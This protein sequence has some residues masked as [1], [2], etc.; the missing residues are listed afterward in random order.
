MFSD[1]PKKF[2]SGKLKL[3]PLRLSFK[4]SI[5][6]CFVAVLLASRSFAQTSTNNPGEKANELS[7]KAPNQE[8]LSTSIEIQAKAYVEKMNQRLIRAT[9]IQTEF[10]QGIESLRQACGRLESGK[11][12]TQESLFIS[13][14]GSE[15]TKKR[16]QIKVLLAKGERL[17]QLIDAQTNRYCLA[18]LRP[19]KRAEL[20][21]Q[22]GTKLSRF[23]RLVDTSLTAQDTLLA[24]REISLKQLQTIS[25]CLSSN[26]LLAL[27]T[28]LNRDIGKL[29]ADIERE[30]AS[31]L[32]TIDGLTQSLK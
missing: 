7:G 4:L 23:E 14:A 20:I 10:D 6:I 18:M 32:E 26:R 5:A 30:I 13:T 22:T 9:H 12:S 3:C 24:Q 16:S 1:R 21:C 2:V 31:G 8:Q 15:I 17:K 19:T 11:T 27:N 28:L 25:T 29:D